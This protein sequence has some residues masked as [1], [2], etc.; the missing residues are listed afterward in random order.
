MSGCRADD[1]ARLA[2]TNRRHRVQRSPGDRGRGRGRPHLQAGALW[3]PCRSAPA[4]AIGA[5]R[6]ATVNA[7]EANGV[8]SQ[9]IGLKNRRGQLSGRMGFGASLRAGV[10][11]NRRRARGG[12]PTATR[13]ASLPPALAPRVPLREGA[14]GRT[15]MVPGA[16]RRRGAWR[17]AQRY[18]TATERTPFRTNGDGKSMVQQ[19]YPIVRRADPRVG[20]ALR[21]DDAGSPARGRP[22]LPFPRA[23]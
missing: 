19:T 13:L 20:R 2:P 7:D 22:C 3:V 11:A 21:P 5:G 23:R 8:K 18:R 6:A 17:A 1:R 9:Q 12:T 14:G 10:R 16:G 15:R 4:A